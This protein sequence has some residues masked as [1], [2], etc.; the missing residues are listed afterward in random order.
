AERVVGGTKVTLFDFGLTAGIVFTSSTE[1]V[2]RFQEQAKGRRQLAAQWSHDMAAYELEKV[3]K[4]EDELERQ[5]HTLPDARMLLADA[6]SRLTASKRQWEN[7]AFPEAYREA[8]R[9][10]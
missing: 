2:A 7:R 6:Q 5:G 8:Q 10:L 3:A 1:L 9:A 4:I